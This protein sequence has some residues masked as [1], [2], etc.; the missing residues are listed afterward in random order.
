MY[1]EIKA[2]Q[3]NSPGP[4]DT[5]KVDYTGTLADGTVF[6]SSI[7]RGVPAE[8]P[9][10]RV[11]TGWQEGVAMMKPGG[12]ARLTIPARLAYGSKERPNIPANSV[13]QFEIELSAQLPRPNSCLTQAAQR[14]S[15][16]HTPLYATL[17]SITQ[18]RRRPVC[19]VEVASS[20]PIPDDYLGRSLGSFSFGKGKD[21]AS[22]PP[23]DNT[24]QLLGLGACALIG[25]L[26]Y[27][28]ILS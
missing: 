25:L 23:K 5:V 6:D 13:L 17:S 8:F 28:G 4:E 14:T 20:V 10:S 3:G 16:W 2:G 1:E 27:T 11:I 9:L 22:S 26:S 21:A 24:P 12:K 19:A 7:A 15:T 18:R